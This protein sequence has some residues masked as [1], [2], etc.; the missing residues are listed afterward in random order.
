METRK[1][2]LSMSRKINLGDY[3]QLEIS[4]MPTIEI[5]SDDDLD[6]ILR[7]AWKMCRAN[8]EHAARPI[9]A[10]YKIGQKHGL[11]EQEVSLGI[12]EYIEE[13]MEIIEEEE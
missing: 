10:G 13:R 7:A 8:I 2:T 6:V 3:N 11:T 4:I 9:L 1:I 5:G 12:A